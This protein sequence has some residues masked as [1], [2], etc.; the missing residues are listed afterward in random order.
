MRP[1]AYILIE[2]DVMQALAEFRQV[3]PNSSES[4]GLLIGYFRGV[5]LHITMLTRPMPGDK[6]SRFLFERRDLGHIKTLE[7]AYKNS[8]GSINLLG[9]WHTH[10]EKHP[11]PSQIDKTGWEKLQKLRM[12]QQTIF[13]IVGTHSIWIGDHTGNRYC[14]I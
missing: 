6:R 4:G 13:I 8:G 7:A 11:K 9:E 10:P 5:H 14:A 2:S 3:S 12:D 1:G